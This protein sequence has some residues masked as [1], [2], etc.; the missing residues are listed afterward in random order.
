MVD[1]PTRASV[2]AD[3]VK[4]IMAVDRPHPV[5]VGIDGFSAA[6]KTTLA[7]ELTSPIE[8]S[9]RSALRASLD[10]FK[11]PVVRRGRY[12]SGT[13]EEYYYEMY[14]HQA[15]RAELLEPLGPDGSRR[16]RTATFDQ[17]RQADVPVTRGTATDDAIMLVDGAFLYRPELNDLWDFRIFVDIDFELVLE[18]G[19][20]R[21]QAW[22]DSL[23]AAED[24]YRNRYI[25][26]EKIY[27]EAVRPHE[28][29]D[30]VVD[31][32][33]LRYPRLQA[34]SVREKGAG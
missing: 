23:A 29:A 8:E 15:I 24:R 26:G 18:R 11:L 17:R 27:W 12:P 22:M 33:D 3:L 7:D 34:P 19:S 20:R 30:V 14:D 25:P 4:L 1:A 21:D 2:I 13:P 10:D 5:R 32:R 31:N 28:H 9:G 16:F 6:G